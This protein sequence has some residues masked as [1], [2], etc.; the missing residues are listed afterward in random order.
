MVALCNPVSIQPEICIRF[1]GNDSSDK[2]IN[3]YSTT[4][5]N[6]GT[7][8]G[9]NGETD[10]AYEWNATTDYLSLSSAV[11][12]IIRTSI[13]N[14]SCTIS[15]F[16]YTED[17][18]F[19]TGRLFSQWG[20]SGNRSFRVSYNALSGG[21][22]DN[23]AITTSTNG[24]DNTDNVTSS[25]PTEFMRGQWNFIQV[26]YDGDG[27]VY[28]DETLNVSIPSY[29]DVYDGTAEFR[30][31]SDNSSVLNSFYGKLHTFKVH[32]TK[33]NLGELNTLRLQQGRII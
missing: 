19:L 24:T 5:N 33:L 6:I 27:T 26:V 32:L 14:H 30:I 31:G 29:S 23:I 11:G 1:K 10:G 12:D 20:N 8:T 28:V 2:S 3:N 21:D 18:D 13:N 22:N 17:T 9:Q 25:S 15:F 16:L 4:E 7:T